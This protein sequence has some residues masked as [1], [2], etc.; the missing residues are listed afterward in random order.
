MRSRARVFS[1]LK[2]QQKHILCRDEYSGKNKNKKK[3]NREGEIPQKQQS[4]VSNFSMV[5]LPRVS[6]RVWERNFRGADDRRRNIGSAV[7]GKTSYPCE[8][9]DC[10]NAW[11]SGAHRGKSI[12]AYA[13]EIYYNIT[14]SGNGDAKL[15]TQFGTFL[16]ISSNFVC[17]IN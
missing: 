7:F 4:E 8:R 10:R 17:L 1:Y 15:L 16:T 13:I 6:R 2:F 3:K 5:V 11:P 12:P 14:A 9:R